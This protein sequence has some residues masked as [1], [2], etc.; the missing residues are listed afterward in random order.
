MAFGRKLRCRLAQVD[1]RPFRL[2]PAQ[3]LT[4][5]KGPVRAR[6]IFVC[7]AVGVLTSGCVT[8]AL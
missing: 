4:D 8:A 1:A 5:A 6:F 7:A 2:V 3:V